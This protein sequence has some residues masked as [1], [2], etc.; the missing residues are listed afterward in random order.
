MKRDINIALSHARLRCESGLQFVHQCH[1]Q[2][3]S[4]SPTG[5]FS[6]TQTDTHLREKKRILF[7]P[8]II[9]LQLHG[10][11]FVMCFSMP[12]V[13]FPD[14]R[15]LNHLHSLGHS[16]VKITG[17][18]LINLPWNQLKSEQN[19]SLISEEGGEKDLSGNISGSEKDKK[20]THWKK[21]SA[22]CL[23]AVLT[24]MSGLE[25]N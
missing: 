7:L 11:A 15:I 2:A 21:W 6:T 9:K 22:V 3:I 16:A 23:Q 19:N 20:H 24:Y 17:K 5:K 10:A 1:C 8:Q 4:L 12:R 14:W 18:T 25:T 13:I